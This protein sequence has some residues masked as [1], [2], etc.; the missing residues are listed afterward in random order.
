M[1]T[2]KQIQTLPQSQQF[3]VVGVGASAGGLD[4]FKRFIDA[5]P[6]KSGMA[7]VLVQHLSP[8]HE[9]ALTEI[10][11]KIS[12]IPVLEITDDAKIEVDTVYVIP[13]NKIITTTDGILKLSSRDSVKTNLI[14]DVF[15]MSL[16]V[17]R[18][19]FAIGVVLS[20]SGSDGT[21]GLK[22]IREYGGIT[23]AQDQESAAFGDM[24]LS[25][26]NSKVVDFVLPPEKIPGHLI[27]INR[28]SRTGLQA[29][30]SGEK[31]EKDDAVFFKQMLALLHQHS[32]VDF[33]FYK[34]N[35]V[36][37]RIAR[38]MAIHKKVKLEDYLRLLREDKAELT[39]LFQDMLI[40]V[41]AFFRDPKIFETLCQTVFPD[42][43]AN[44]TPDDPIR[45]WIA[46]CS[47]GEEAY[48]VAMC[49]HEFFGKNPSAMK[50]QIFASD[51]SEVAIRK[52]RLGIYSK[53]EVADVSQERLEKYFT[54]SHGNFMVGKAIRDMCVFAVHNFL[55]DPPFAKM[56]FIS[57]RNVFIYLDSFLQKKALT[58]FHYALNQNGVLMLGKSETIG[59]AAELFTTL[60]PW[61]K[62]FS[63]KPFP[64]RFM[65]VA[66]K[67][68]EDNLLEQNKPDQGPKADPVQ[69]DFRK[70]AE[71]IMLSA[72]PASVIVN[73]QMDIVHIHGDVTPFLRP[74][75]GKPTF[76]IFK[77]AREGLSFELRNTI[78]KS[79]STG[80]SLQEEISLK[81]DGKQSLIS[82]KVVPLP[83][84][85]DPYYLVFFTETVEENPSISPKGGASAGDGAV[86]RS[87]EL[88]KELS[89]LRM[90]MRAI[91]EE[92]DSAN[93]ELQ[94]INEELQSSN[95]ELQSLNEELE[96]SKEELQSVNEELT[97]SNQELIEKQEQ[98]YA[99]R[100]YS[101][102]IVSTIREPL[103]VLDKNLIVKSINESFSTKFGVSADGVQGR[104]FLS[105]QDQRWEIGP[106][107][108]WLEDILPGKKKK[109]N[110]EIVLQ[111]DGSPNTFILNAQQIQ[112]EQ[113]A[114]D[115]IL[116]AL[117]DVT[118]S[119]MNKR[120]QESESRFRQLSDQIPH[121]VFTADLKGKVNYA[122]KVMVDYT[123]KNLDELRGDGWLEAI[124][125]DDREMALKKW[126][127]G[128][129]TGEKVLMQLR[130]RKQDGT[131][132]WHMINAVP[133]KDIR[134]MILAWIGTF[135]DIHE[136]KNFAERL[137]EKV[138]ERTSELEKTNHQLNQ[139]AYTASHDLQEPLRKIMTFSKRLKS[140]GN[141]ELQEDIQVYLEKIE[142]ASSRMSILIRDLLNFARMSDSQD[143]FQQTD[144][145]VTLKNILND[146]EILI[147][148][149]KAK[150]KSDL[151]PVIEAI[152]LQIN[153]LFYNLV[154]NALKFSREDVSPVLTIT[155]SVLSSEQIQKYGSLNPD[156]T[157]YQLS[158]KDNGIGFDQQYV[159]QIFIIFQRLNQP[160]QYSGTGI[161]L[162]LSKKIVERH[163]GEIF[164]VGHV[165]EGAEFHVIL[166]EKQV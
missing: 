137:E 145:N 126:M 55:K 83:N 106:L 150:I 15:F 110:L 158:F 16:A 105:I 107:R 36:R 100:Y 118:H 91:A 33:T 113:N 130:V 39:A 68:R 28:N 73:D 4:A 2:G 11:Q 109:E 10:L 22:M 133:Q 163:H 138:R 131:Y 66:T 116:L 53:E 165:N 141:E 64:G 136:Q 122:N 144:L 24:P 93:E 6:E 62:L 44:K 45:I 162:A 84:T 35:T 23:V 38:R 25:A 18:D 146:Y 161:G 92:H 58:M 123:G 119:V 135:T 81:G 54:K 32:N 47:T 127:N 98:L 29:K 51:I 27:Q 76:N 90:D 95:E 120:L 9:S 132:Q 34:Q 78:H 125:P 124:S 111:I 8:N 74:S 153:Q 104:Y 160:T 49:L 77:M 67:R 96:T 50:I 7:Y 99:A 1:K 114:E 30:E 143:L 46:G 70:I 19:S 71:S 31:P 121:L 52:A 166:P 142:G 43:F 57:C 151:L 82:I 112:N 157:Y 85:V 101:D 97:V 40:P 61:D 128:V 129:R 65:H 156:L 148:E 12:K 140:T 42:L 94:S 17:I 20:G 87:E 89:Q 159:H 60:N 59:A 5:I 164:A 108:D 26:V 3:P 75:P 88:E 48:S 86:L 149:K 103:V 13:S 139:F 115:L 56:D 72:A 147:E 37:R 154:G 102:A 41:T 69:A 80:K 134:G 21:V 152:P 79:K 155:C 117:E 63:R 14:I